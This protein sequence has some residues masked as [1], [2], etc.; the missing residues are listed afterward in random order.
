MTLSKNELATTVADAM[1]RAPK[2]RAEIARAIAEYA[3]EYDPKDEKSIRD[4][5]DRP[6][7]SHSR[8][9]LFGKL[10]ILREAR[11]TLERLTNERG[12][13]AA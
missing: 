11:A 2:T 5:L 6:V 10:A 4:F 8:A 9:E 12:T 7:R 13:R 1:K 3:A